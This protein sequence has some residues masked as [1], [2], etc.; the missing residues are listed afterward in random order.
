MRESVGY[1]IVS[2]IDTSNSRLRMLD[3]PGLKE[4]CQY[5]SIAFTPHDD[6]TRRSTIYPTDGRFYH[7]QK[8]SAIRVRSRTPRRTVYCS[9][10]LLGRQ[11]C[12]QRSCGEAAR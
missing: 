2:E 6:R 12:S 4:C 7:E 9:G 8:R 5:A 10:G 11:R 3:E 1:I